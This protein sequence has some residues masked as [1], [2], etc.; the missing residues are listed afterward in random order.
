MTTNE[1]DVK[2]QYLTFSLADEEFGVPVLVVKEILEYGVVTR[3]PR[4][5]SHVRGVIN[6]RGR[7]VP[8]VD[9]AIRLGLHPRPLTQRTCVVVVEVQVEG[10]RVVAGLVVDAVSRVFEFAPADIEP[11]VSFGANLES[12]FLTGLGRVGRSFVLLLDVER[13]VATTVSTPS[14]CV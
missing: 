10:E 12:T 3:V 9:L 1:T 4:A 13:L 6:L 8:L 7:V 11:A 2:L 5:P 14:L